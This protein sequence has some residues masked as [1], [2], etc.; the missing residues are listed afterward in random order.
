MLATALDRSELSLDGLVLWDPCESGR[1]FLREL[2]ALELLR[3]DHAQDRDDGSIETA[4]FLFA[5]H[6]ATE[7]SSLRLS[8]V[9]TSPMAAHVLVVTRDDRRLPDRLHHRLERQPW[10]G[11]RP[12]SR[13]G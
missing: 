12:P 6:V 11:S 7:L 5:D 4:E 8:K 13:C 3:S 1:A 2:R 10:S 9:A